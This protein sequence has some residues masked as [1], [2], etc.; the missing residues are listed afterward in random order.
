MQIFMKNGKSVNPIDQELGSSVTVVLP[1]RNLQMTISKIK[2][3]GATG[4]CE[5]KECGPIKTENGKSIEPNSFSIP[6]N[7]SMHEV[8][9]QEFSESGVLFL[10]NQFMHA[11]G[12]TLSYDPNKLS[13]Q[14]TINRTKFRGFSDESITKGYTNVAKY[15]KENADDLI[16]EA[17][18]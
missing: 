4:I 2:F 6:I 1:D 8:S 7:D 18:E 16:K 13:S 14:L 5:L 12:F 11:F 10:V 3:D 9:V 17:E 15:M